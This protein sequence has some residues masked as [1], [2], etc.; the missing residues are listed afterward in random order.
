[1]VVDNEG[2]EDESVTVDLAADGGAV[3]ST[4]TQPIV[5]AMGESATFTF[6]WDTTTASVGDHTLTATA[7]LQG[8]TDSDPADNSQSASVAVLA[9]VH[10]VAV[11]SIVS[12][13]VVNYPDTLGIQV[14]VTNEGTFEETFEVSMTDTPPAGGMPGTWSSALPNPAPVTLPAGASTSLIFIWETASASE[15]DHVLTATASGVASETDTADNSQSKTVNVSLEVVDLA[16]NSVTAPASVTEGS[17]ADVL[18]EV[19]NLGTVE[20]TVTV[21]VDDTMDAGNLG[22]M[23]AP[24][25]VTLA[26]SALT[27]LTF[28]W[29]TTA[30]SAGDHLLSSI[31]SP[32]GGDGDPN[33]N[34][35]ITV[36]TV[37]LAAPSNLTATAG[38]ETTGR[39]KTKTVT[40]VWVDLAWDDNSGSEQG[41]VIER[42]EVTVSG[43][44]KGKKNST[45][46]EYI[47][48][49]PTA[50]DATSYRDVNA[51]RTDSV[52]GPRVIAVNLSI[53]SNCLTLMSL[54]AGCDLTPAA[55]GPSRKARTDASSSNR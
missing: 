24:Q 25:E 42:A 35:N 10:D 43:K 23:S 12:Q 41:Y 14:D 34:F 16:I 11:T 37:L 31:F 13:D 5:I 2:T 3:Q 40:A 52:T 48:F 33:N 15:G 39:G 19:E 55:S 8:E 47:P 51:V 36:S 54:M 6:D 38:A 9:P 27:T 28:T 17:V 26:G 45:V 4:N 18:V 20:M 44:G 49:G 46:G 1:V 22:T 50:A 21:S 30:A 7:S 32:V 53:T 29:D